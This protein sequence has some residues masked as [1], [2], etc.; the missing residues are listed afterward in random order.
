MTKVSIEVTREAAQRANKKLN[1]FVGRALQSGVEAA[2]TM[3][4]H[5]N[6]L[7]EKAR[8]G[9]FGAFSALQQSLSRDPVDLGM[10]WKQF[11]KENPGHP[12]PTLPA[13]RQGKPRRVRRSVEVDP[14]NPPSFIPL[15]KKR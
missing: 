4:A 1:D 10:E 9:D 8:Q 2:E 15:P 6:H 5:R 3:R 12:Q 14:D 7:I 13:R 11:Q